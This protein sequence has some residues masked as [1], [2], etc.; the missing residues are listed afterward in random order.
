MQSVLDNKITL[1]HCGY[2]S[3]DSYAGAQSEYQQ[4]EHKYFSG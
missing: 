3:K 4:I 2:K 1:L